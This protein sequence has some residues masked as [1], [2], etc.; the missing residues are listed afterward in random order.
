MLMNIF[1]EQT[2]LCM[3]ITGMQSNVPYISGPSSR[4]AEKALCAHKPFTELF[5]EAGPCP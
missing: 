3:L 1:A 2:E 4:C 5:H